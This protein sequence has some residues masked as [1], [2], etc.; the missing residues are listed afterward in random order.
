MS[1]RIDGELHTHTQSLESEHLG[2]AFD[3]LCESRRIAGGGRTSMSGLKE[4]RVAISCIMHSFC[5]LEGAINALGYE[6]FFNAQSGR[7]VPKDARDH[8][9]ERFL[10]SWDKAPCLEK[11][12]FIVSYSGARRVP[13]NL[14][15]RLRELN[16]LRNWLVHGFTFE[17]TFLLEPNPTEG[18]GSFTVVDYEESVDWK[19]KFPNTHFN[20]LMA[21]YHED[22]RKAMHISL[23]CLEILSTIFTQPYAFTVTNP[24]MGFQILMGPSFDI[25]GVLE[26]N[27]S[28]QEPDA[29]PGSGTYI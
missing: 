17:T 6:L 5:F 23:E 22:A 4:R 7:Y 2:Q 21:L 25:E 27:T 1:M 11:L 3:L 10:T 20:S 26:R 18:D 15:A 24:Q 16:T 19:A 12:H 14:A 8:L 13:D 29:Q 9:L 28:V